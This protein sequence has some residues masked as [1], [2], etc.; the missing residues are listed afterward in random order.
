M[1]VFC[2]IRQQ[3]DP[4]F[5]DPHTER[6]RMK[7]TTSRL[8]LFTTLLAVKQKKILENPGTV[9]GVN[10]LIANVRAYRFDQLEQLVILTRKT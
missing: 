2:G 6:L 4:A 5:Y 7:R 3:I 9:D 8:S 10:A 1:K